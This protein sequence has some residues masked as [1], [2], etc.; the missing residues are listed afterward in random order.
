MLA[1]RIHIQKLANSCSCMPMLVQ[2]W[3]AR[4]MVN[5]WS[6]DVVTCLCW[7]NVVWPDW[8][9]T[10]GQQLSL[11]VY[12]DPMLA[13]QMHSQRLLNSYGFMP[14]LAQYWLARFTANS[15]S[16]VLKLCCVSPI[17]ICWPN[18]P[19][20]GQQL[21]SVNISQPIKHLPKCFLRILRES[22]SCKRDILSG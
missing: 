6:T 8:W 16:T 3:L 21:W 12:V 10:V 18:T 17:L 7:P 2:W 13:Y 11:H 14:M 5:S 4:L 9:S 20:V 22:P 19:M 15:W 1:G